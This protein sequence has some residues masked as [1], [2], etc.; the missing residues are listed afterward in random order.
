[1]LPPAHNAVFDLHTGV[2]SLQ[3]Y[4][5]PRRGNRRVEP[6]EFR[7]SLKKA[8]ERRLVSDVPISISLSGGTDSTAVAA[9]TAQLTNSEIKAFTTAT[10]EEVGDETA[11]IAHFLKQ[12]P[13]FQLEKSSLSEASF[14]EHYRKIIFHMDEPFVRQSAYVRWE[15]AN[16][17]ERCG[18][19]VLLNGEGADEI[20]GGYVPFAPRFLIDL[21]KRHRLIRF[22]REFWS[23]LVHPERRRMFDAFRKQLLFEGSARA[24]QEARAKEFQRKFGVKLDRGEER[25]PHYDDI[26][27]YLFSLVH[28]YSLPRLL[29]CN[30]KMTMANSV[31]GRAPFLDHEF[32]DLAFSMDPTELVVDGWRKFPLRQAM[33]E[34][35]PDEI[36]FRK[37]KSAFNAPI[38][39]YLRSESIRQ[40]IKQIFQEPRTAAVFSPETYVSEYESFLSRRGGDRTFLL[41]GLFLEEW[42]RMFEVEFV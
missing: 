6:D 19:K 8:V 9:L 30:D 18:R 14:C 33:R 36:L 32:V 7:A 13:Q 2:M 31:E 11:L 28:D 41:H 34:L 27:D 1:M 24:A 39:N 37:C 21:L 17:T 38:F 42:A 16:L 12:Y 35:V 25:T 3:K 23:A 22:G 40:R 15:I 5:E 10:G 20:L 4:Y 29:N 26:K